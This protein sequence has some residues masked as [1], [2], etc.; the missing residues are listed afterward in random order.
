ML[1]SIRWGSGNSGGS[2]A[3]CLL[4]YWRS[5]TGDRPAQP[6]RAPIAGHPSWDSKG[7]GSDRQG[8]RM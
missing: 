5:I 8:N 1:D 6:S 2:V 3:G 7:A 4:V